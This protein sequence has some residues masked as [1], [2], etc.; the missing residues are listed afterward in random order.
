[1]LIRRPINEENA[2]FNV[3]GNS[4]PNITDFSATIKC[5]ATGPLTV[6]IGQVFE[7]EVELTNISKQK[8]F[9][10]GSKAVN[11]CYHWLDSAGNMLVFD[12][13]RTPLPCDVEPGKT[14][15][16]WASVIAPAQPGEARLQI[17]LV[18]EHVG[19]FDE[20]GSLPAEIEVL[21]SPC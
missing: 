3:L 15:R 20:R 5:L 19:W 18:Q 6:S 7:I 10:V 2:G 14:V 12:G 21:V 11:I 8:W 4:I 17:T 1:M 9:S 16:L 13:K